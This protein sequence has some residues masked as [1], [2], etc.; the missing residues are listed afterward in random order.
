MSAD[1]ALVAFETAAS[2]LFPGDLNGAFD[3]FV[4]RRAAQPGPD[5]L[6]RELIRTVADLRLHHGLERSLTA[7]LTAALRAVERGQPR[8]ACGPL[9]AF[10]HEVTAQAGKKLTRS[11]AARLLSGARRIEAALA[12]GRA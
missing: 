9:G 11:Q 6:I 5:E 3:V 12:C 8:R 10:R 4:S 2:N 1:G 7:K